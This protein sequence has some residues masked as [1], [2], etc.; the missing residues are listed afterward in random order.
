AAR[1]AGGGTVRF[2]AGM[3]LSVS[4]HLQSHVTLCLEP[5]AVIVAAETADG[6]AYDPP[7]P[8]APADKYEDFGHSHWHNSLIWGEGLEN[9]SI[10][11]P[12]LIYGRGL[13]R[14][15]GAPKK[16]EGPTTVP[17]MI[18]PAAGEPPR[19]SAATREAATNPTYPNK[20]DTLPAGVGN[21]A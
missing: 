21:K 15:H 18:D 3:Y 12:G 14:G 6:V 8:N 4:I 5:G 9:V 19:S 17:A 10:V 11:G 16:H 1:T 7:E 2:P 20:R 13:S